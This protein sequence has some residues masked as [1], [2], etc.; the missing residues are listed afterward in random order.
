MKH[1]EIKIAEEQKRKDIETNFEAHYKGIEEQMNNEQSGFFDEN[2]ES[3]IKR[4]NKS[5][6]EKYVELLKEIDEKKVL[7]ANQ[8]VEKSAG[9]EKLES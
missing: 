6:E 9:T 4:E 5:L 8:L 7:M 1:A 2:G 3:E